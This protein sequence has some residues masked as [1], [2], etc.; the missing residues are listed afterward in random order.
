[1]TTWW[2]AA[3]ATVFDLPGVHKDQETGEYMV[4]DG[5]YQDEDG[6]QVYCS[7]C[8]AQP[9]E[10][11]D[12]PRLQRDNPGAVHQARKNFYRYRPL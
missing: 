4:H 11:C 3:L 6:L 8:G 1:M 2:K 7:Q 9:G 10:P 12:A 5:P